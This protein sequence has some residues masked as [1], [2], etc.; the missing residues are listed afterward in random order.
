M[1]QQQVEE[2]MKR[3][4]SHKGVKALII[5]NKDGLLLKTN[6]EMN[7]TTEQL[8]KNI[9]ELSLAARRLIRD[10]DPHDDLMFLRTLSDKDEILI[11]P[12]V[13][14]TVIV[15]QEHS[16]DVSKVASDASW[17]S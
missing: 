1:S 11:S 4:N 14:F 5:I 2:I 17:T 6:M 3:I 16:G 10:V 15:I 13:N 7:A 9:H 12:D 8:I